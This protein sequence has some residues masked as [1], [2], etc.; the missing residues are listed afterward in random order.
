MKKTSNK[1][2]KEGG[3]L[4]LTFLCCFL[5]CLLLTSLAVAQHRTAHVH[6]ADLIAKA[7][8]A[9]RL[10]IAL[11]VTKNGLL[12]APYHCIAGVDSILLYVHFCEDTLEA[13]VVDSFP[14]SDLALLRVDLPG[15]EV[16]GFVPLFFLDL[17]SRFPFIVEVVFVTIGRLN[18]TSYF[19]VRGVISWV[20]RDTIYVC[21]ESTLVTGQSGSPV[22]VSAMGRATN[23]VVG[24][25]Q[26]GERWARLWHGSRWLVFARSTFGIIPSHSV[27]RLLKKHR[28]P[29][30][31]RR[32][33]DV[34]DFCSMCH[35]LPKHMKPK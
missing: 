6:L 11:F 3:H 24:V 30:F 23:V 2:D 1:E 29:Y 26:S 4:A 32:P 22:L 17:E 31:V 9:V 35:R 20:S 34:R 16:T 13:E 14:D 7:S 25:L 8:P 5:S 19:M 27:M 28:I 18:P 33:G 15:G 12:I 10:G 21:S